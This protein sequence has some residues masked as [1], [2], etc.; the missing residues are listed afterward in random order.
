MILLLDFGGCLWFKGTGVKSLESLQVEGV[1][2]SVIRDDLW[3]AGGQIGFIPFTPGP[4]AEAG[5]LVDRLALMIVKGTAD[6]F[7]EKKGVFSL[8]T[9]GNI[10]N[11]LYVIEGQVEEFDTGSWW[12]FIGIGKKNMTFKIKGE[13]RDRKTGDVVARITGFK[14]FRRV[15]DAEKVAYALGFSIGERVQH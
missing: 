1:T 2:V 15:R 10:D 11:A 5:Q 12:K 6:S 8:I 13:V 4:N 9:D 3:R 7:I 14:A